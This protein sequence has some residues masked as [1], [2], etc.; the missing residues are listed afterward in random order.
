MT[1]RP[2]LLSLSSSVLRG[3]GQ[4]ILF[5]RGGEERTRPPRPVLPLSGASGVAQS[6][7]EEGGSQERYRLFTLRS[8]LEG[9]VGFE[10]LMNA[11]KF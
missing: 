7:V 5:V 9:P 6:S 3:F 10:I 2:S 1:H 8:P 11:V 4:G